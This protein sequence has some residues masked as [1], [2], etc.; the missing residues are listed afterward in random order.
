M[1]LSKLHV[2]QPWVQPGR[3]EAGREREAETNAFKSQHFILSP[4]S[5]SGYLKFFE[6]IYWIGTHAIARAPR[7]VNNIPGIYPVY[8]GVCSPNH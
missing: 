6:G 8:A 3:A 2:E 4:T 5:E 1:Q 7:L